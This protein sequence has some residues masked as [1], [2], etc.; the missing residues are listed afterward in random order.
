M[1]ELAYGSLILALLVSPIAALLIIRD[2]YWA[3]MKW[4]LNRNYRRLY[5][6]IK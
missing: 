6:F 2:L 3:Y 5:W 4:R 1:K